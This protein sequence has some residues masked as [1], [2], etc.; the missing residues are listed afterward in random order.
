MDDPEVLSKILRNYKAQL[1]KR[2][3][4]RVIFSADGRV[5]FTPFDKIIFGKQEIR[6]LARNPGNIVFSGSLE[7]AELNAEIAKRYRFDPVF[8]ETRDAKNPIL[9]V[10]VLDSSGFGGW[11]DIVA[12]EFDSWENGCSFGVL[13][14]VAKPARNFEA[15]LSEEYKAKKQLLN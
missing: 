7:N 12:A 3:E 5:R 8:Y 4:R 14:S 6:T 2:E 9:R 1:G 13:D 11:L 15:L 10:P